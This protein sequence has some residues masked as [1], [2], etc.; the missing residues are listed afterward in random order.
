MGLTEE[1]AKLVQELIKLKLKL[2]D[3]ERRHEVT[4]SLTALE[5]IRELEER[6]KELEKELGI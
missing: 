2:A 4:L 3:Q 1:Q 6:V 5:Q